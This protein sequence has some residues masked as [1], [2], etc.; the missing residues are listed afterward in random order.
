MDN[1]SNLPMPC[2][3]CTYTYVKGDMVYKNGTLANTGNGAY[4][5]HITLVSMPKG[6]FSPQGLR[7]GLEALTNGAPKLSAAPVDKFFWIPAVLI[8]YWE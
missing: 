8:S 3:G 1:L 5:H 6:K 2:R 7:Q 4:M